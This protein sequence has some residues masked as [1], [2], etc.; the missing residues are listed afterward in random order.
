MVLRSHL[1]AVVRENYLIIIYQVS[2][3]PTGMK[4]GDPRIRAVEAFS[5]GRMFNKQT[6]S[7]M[8]HA[9]RLLEIW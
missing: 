2:Q 8:F 7:T 6:D 9:L 5:L 1:I 3:H 4:V